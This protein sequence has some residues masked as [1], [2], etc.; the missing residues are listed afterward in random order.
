[1]PYSLRPHGLLPSR[2]LCP[3]DHQARNTGVG[4][5]FLLQG[6]FS[7]K[8]LS[9]HFLHW[10]AN[11]LP[12]DQNV[13]WCILVF[14][15]QMLLPFIHHFLRY[16][17]HYTRNHSNSIYFIPTIID[18]IYNSS[19]HVNYIIIF[20]QLTFWGTEIFRYKKWISTLLA[21]SS[22]ILGWL[23]LISGCFSCKQISDHTM[24]ADI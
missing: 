6:N 3:W 21:Y 12:K 14:L 16:L 4:C 13:T 5:Y 22:I 10:Y 2:L 11:S 1:M 24:L 15:L 20:P 17:F 9:P 18:D 7:I 19:Y 23:R 8:G